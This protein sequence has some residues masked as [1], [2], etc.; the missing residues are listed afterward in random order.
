M[1]FNRLENLI[2][3]DKI[4]M[5]KHKHIVVFGLGGVGSFAA[6]ALVRS[7]IGKLTL[8]DYDIV[9][10]T[11]INRQLIAKTST[12]G[13]K[14]VEVFSRRAKDI[15]PDIQIIAIDEA[16]NQD[17][18]LSILNPLPDFVLDCIDD[19][20]GKLELV[21]ACQTKQIPLI[22]AMGFANKFHPE[23]I[24]LSTLKKTSVCPLARSVRKLVRDHGLSLDVACVYSEEKPAQVIDKTILGST[25]F[26]PSSAGLMMASY[27][28]NQ[29]L[30]G[31]AL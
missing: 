22:L 4:E 16:V 7:G 21:K 12:I 2:G 3:H 5:L 10:I 26:C 18:V 25:A 27:V 23:M 14:K 11:N 30:E 29:I 6:E 19:V 15:N 28:I 13:L 1:L 17:N 8:V 20:A 31:D 9:D 24:R